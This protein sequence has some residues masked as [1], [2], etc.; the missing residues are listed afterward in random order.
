M[1]ERRS[2]DGPA[3]HALVIGVGDYP[4]AMGRFGISRI[5]SP[6]RSALALT[7]WLSD[8]YQNPEAPLAT[9]ELVASPADVPTIAAIERKILDW[10]QRCDTDPGNI[11]LFYFCG[12][13]LARGEDLALLADDFG[14]AGP[15]NPL[16]EAL[17]L[18]E[19]CLGMERCRAQRQC[20]LID[21]CRNEDPSLVAY[22]GPFGQVPL[23]PGPLLARPRP[24]DYSVY[25]AAGAGQAAFGPNAGTSVFTTALLEA[26]DGLGAAS[27]D[28]SDP[29]W[30]VTT[31][32]LQQ[33]LVD[34]MRRAQARA[35]APVQEPK[36][37]GKSGEWLLHVAAEAPKVPVVIGCDPE[38]DNA[39]AAMRVLRGGA[40][41]E[42]RM[43]TENNW[44]LSLP[45]A[46]Y[47]LAVTPLGSAEKRSLWH[48]R[49]P[50][51]RRRVRVS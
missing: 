2:I 47:E 25:F 10:A 12:H 49:P 48:V 13:G 21:C 40:L 42:S 31:L 3:T 50:S 37:G 15:F 27:D 45:A 33:A 34:I 9:I 46:I 39:R 30:E 4:A 32:G 22:Q 41:V 17:A 5:A 18:E 51:V 36:L 16:A 8:R 6:P 14:A 35:G 19:L 44:E 11:A 43:P 20:F 24:R 28:D 26:L 1:I 38:Q 7:Q 29:R 23:A